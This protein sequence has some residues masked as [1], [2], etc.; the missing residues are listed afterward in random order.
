MVF[1]LKAFVCIKPNDLLKQHMNKKASEKKEFYLTINL[2]YLR[3]ESLHF[4]S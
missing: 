2:S 1:D 3:E 4:F